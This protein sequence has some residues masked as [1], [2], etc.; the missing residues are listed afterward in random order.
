MQ[1]LLEMASA[2]RRHSLVKRRWG[3]HLLAPGYEYCGKSQYVL[4]FIWRTGLNDT[5][6]KWN[7]ALKH[8]PGWIRC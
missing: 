1:E 6:L 3:L 5:L 4:K 2:E 8:Q 7:F